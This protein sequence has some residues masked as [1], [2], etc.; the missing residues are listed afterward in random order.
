MELLTILLTLINQCKKVKFGGRRNGVLVALENGQSTAY[1]I[2][3][4]ED[5]GTVF[6]EPGTDVYGGMI[7][8]GK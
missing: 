6:I 1:S 7:V 2:S 4:L 3:S 8:G 5:R